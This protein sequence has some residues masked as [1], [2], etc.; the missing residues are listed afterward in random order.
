MRAGHVELGDYSSRNE[1]TKLLALR[2][3]REVGLRTAEY[4]IRKTWTCT[5]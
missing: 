3:A 4:D 1:N 2:L 5:K